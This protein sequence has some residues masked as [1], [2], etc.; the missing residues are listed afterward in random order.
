MCHFGFILN[1]SI[2]NKF[3]FLILFRC[4]SVC[5]CVCASLTSSALIVASS[6]GGSA[7]LASLVGVLVP[8]AVGVLAPGA[9]G[10]FVPGVAAAAG[11]F[12]PAATGVLVP[13]VAA[14]A[15]VLAPAAAGV[16][17]PGVATGVFFF[18]FFFLLGNTEN[19]Y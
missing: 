11:V 14:A 13:G 16:L 17:V 19:R 1:L 2:R 9:V 10:V 12:A 3:E 6:F 5:M 4:I 18:C 8:A 7:G 15:G